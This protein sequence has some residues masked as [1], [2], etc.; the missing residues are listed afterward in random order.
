M[1]TFRHSFFSTNLENLKSN[2]I[3]IKKYSI[4]KIKILIFLFGIGLL[5]SC[6][7]DDN[8]EIKS[9]KINF[10]EIGKGALHGN[11]QEG[12]SQSNITITNTND[13]LNL[14]SQMNSVSNVSDN[15]TEIDIDFN[16]F[17]VF[18]IFLDVKGNGWKIEIENIIENENNI[19]ISTQE[20]EFANSVMTQPFHII[21]IPKTTKPIIVE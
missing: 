21:K 15:F 3:L 12:I 4:M 20:T 8:S 13:W 11:G 2:Q 9:T 14:I 10:T 19:S 7:S 17:T 18:A 16:E 6:N 5:N 1:N